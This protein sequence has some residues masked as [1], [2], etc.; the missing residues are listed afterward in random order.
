MKKR[1]YSRFEDVDVFST[2]LYEENSYVAKVLKK[3]NITT[4]K[5]LFEKEDANDIDFEI[6][7]HINADYEID[8]RKTKAG[9]EAFL[10]VEISY[11]ECSAEEAK[12][13]FNLIRYKY[14][15]EDVIDDDIIYEKYS[16]ENDL[17][18]KNYDGFTSEDIDSE[19]G[20]LKAIFGNQ[21]EF[22]KKEKVLEVGDVYEK[23]NRLG[24]SSHEIEKFINTM[25]HS[26]D[27]YFPVDLNELFKKTY[28]SSHTFCP[29]GC[30]N[31]SKEAEDAILQS[32]F[33]A[34][35]ARIMI[36][37][38]EILSDCRIKKIQKRESALEKLKD[39]RK[40]FVM[41][42]HKTQDMYEEFKEIDI[43]AVGLFDEN[44]TIAQMLRENGIKTL[45]DLFIKY[46][47]NEINYDIFVNCVY[48]DASEIVEQYESDYESGGFQR[49]MDEFNSAEQFKAIIKLLRYRY[50]GEDCLEDES[51][52]EAELCYWDE[53]TD[54]IDNSNEILV[55]LGFD[56]SE[57]SEIYEHLSEESQW[58]GYYIDVRL[59]DILNIMN[60][61]SRSEIFV[62]KTDILNKCILER[63]NQIKKLTKK[64]V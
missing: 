34:R 31:L 35:K 24:F 21:V 36:K 12:G 6:E 30:Y 44:S 29:A 49:E 1:D 16:Y 27:A 42:N 7:K 32:E 8:E 10:K 18:S 25:E 57:I 54:Y 64:Q 33:I 15:N 28:V 39:S 26:Q 53:Y 45:K 5:E 55:K 51:L 23:L 37:K 4:L 48:E 19:L 22:V 59:T 38:M 52:T 56:S 46:D 60:K 58:Y 20:Y 43:F 11:D 3:N 62:K 13:I 17:F 9:Y 2:G 63:E 40:T 50:L 41:F 61:T 47:N 14:L